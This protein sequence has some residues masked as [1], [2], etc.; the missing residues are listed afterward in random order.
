MHPIVSDFIKIL[1]NSIISGKILGFG[2]FSV[3]RIIK[4]CI[5]FSQNANYGQYILIHSTT[6]TLKLIF[7]Y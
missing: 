1:T 5:S 2:S 7:Y 4:Y 3:R 6:I